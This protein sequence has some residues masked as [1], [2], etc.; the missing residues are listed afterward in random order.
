MSFQGRK[1]SNNSGEW[2]SLGNKKAYPCLLCEKTFDTG[3]AL[4]GH[5]NAHR[6]E[7]EEAASRLQ[8]A[9]VISRYM[10]VQP[11]HPVGGESVKED[12]DLTLKL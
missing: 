5:Q 8:L 4:G 6:K 3:P 9:S 11:H 12:I 7:R 2:L 10:D 1:D